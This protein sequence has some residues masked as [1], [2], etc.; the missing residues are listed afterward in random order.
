MSTPEEWFSMAPGVTCPK[1]EKPRTELGH[2]PC[3][4][5]LPGVRYACC[6][7]GGVSYAYIYFEDGHCIRMEVDAV[8]QYDP[9]VDS[10]EHVRTDLPAGSEK[11]PV[12][13]SKPWRSEAA[14]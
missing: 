5:N 3:I 13:P 4:A 7:H 11:A 2:D 14:E 6:G 8:Q 10:I 9:S 1:C 12:V